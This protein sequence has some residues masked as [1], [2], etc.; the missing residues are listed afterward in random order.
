MYKKSYLAYVQHEEDKLRR[1]LSLLL[2][3]CRVCDPNIW[4]IHLT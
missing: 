2:Y 3:K 4:K 1:Y